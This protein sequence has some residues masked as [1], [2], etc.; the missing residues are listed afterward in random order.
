MKKIWHIIALPVFVLLIL[1]SIGCSGNKEDLKQIES[2]RKPVLDY[3][4]KMLTP[5]LST[6]A[7]DC[8]YDKHHLG[9][10]EQLLSLISNTPLAHNDLREI[11]EK[12]KGDSKKVKIFNN[13][14]Q[15]YNHNLFWKSITPYKGGKLSPEMKQLIVNS[16]GSYERFTQLF[17]D[18]CTSVFGSGWVW[19]IRQGTGIEIMTTSNADTPIAYGLEPIIVLD[20]WE[21]SYYLD[22]QHNRAAYAETFLAHWVNWDYAYRVLTQ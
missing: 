20:V 19:L 21:H 7:V 6:K 10:Y 8:H 16:F 9:Y 14:A 15:V 22:Y 12:T 3:Q 13:A 2:L 4:K 18:A 1:F 11:I 17:V 5:F